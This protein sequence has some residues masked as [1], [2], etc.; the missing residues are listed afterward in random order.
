MEDLMNPCTGEMKFSGKFGNTYPAGVAFPDEFVSFRFQMV[1][2]V[3]RRSYRSMAIEHGE[4]ALH[5]FGYA[6]YGC[7]LKAP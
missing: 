1:I 5:G 4:D 3:T 2:I 6:V 7:V